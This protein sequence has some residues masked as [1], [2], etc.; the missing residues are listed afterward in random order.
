MHVGGWFDIHQQPLLDVFSNLQ[1]KGASPARGNQKLV[2]TP[3]AHILPVKGVKFPGDT[4]MALQAPQTPIRWFNHWL[5]GEDNGVNREPTVRYYLMGDTFDTKAPGNEWRESDVWPPRSTPTSLYFQA[6]GGLTRRKAAKPAQR[7]YVYDPK[8]A[9]P[10][11]GGNNLF[12]DSGPMDQRPVSNRPDVLRFIGEPLETAT[13]VVGN[14]QVRLWVSTDAQDT[15]FIVKLIDIHPDGY[16]ALVH[17]Q[18]FRMRHHKGLFTQTRIEPGKVYQIP[19]DLWSTALVF[20]KGHR[21]GVLVQSS[22]WPRFERHTNTWDPV[23]G[24][25]HAVKATNTVHL[26][27]AYA[28]SITLPVTKIYPA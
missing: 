25:D 8:D 23:A 27:A 22:N 28:S 15:D 17:D 26:G 20:N 6:D 19:V 14:V 18:G 1:T 7:S 3:N 13:E 11:V 21:I 16:E 5:K 4:G 24:Y 9:V 2:M 10:S 12:M